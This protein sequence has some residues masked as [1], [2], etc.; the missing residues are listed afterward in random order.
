MTALI[1]ENRK[2]GIG[3]TGFGALF[4]TMGVVLLFDTKL[5][6]LGN[7]SRPSL[8]PSPPTRHRTPPPRR[9]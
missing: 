7:V 8:R 2:I 3:L 6:I 9:G 5:L 1:N 4:L